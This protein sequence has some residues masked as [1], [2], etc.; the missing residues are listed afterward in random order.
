M[1]VISDVPTSTLA[2]SNV[3]SQVFGSGLIGLREGLEAAIVVSILVAFLVKS[4]R[5]DALK[6]V[7]LGVGAA[8]A[9]TVTV[10]L[11]I[12]F[13]EKTIS[14]LGAEAI[15]GIAS[16]IAVVI[17]TTMVL[18]MKR[19]SASMSGQ[20]R[21][22]MSQALETGGLAVALLAFLAVGREGVETALFMVGYAEAETLWPLTGLIIGV[23]IAAAIAYGMYAGAV[24]INLAKFF[25]YTGIFLVVVAAGILAYGIKALQ[26]VGWIPGLNAKA[27]DMSGAFDWSAWYGEIVQGVFNIDPTPTVLQFSAWLAYIVV[28]LALFLKPIRTAG[29]ASAATSPE[30][31]SEPTAEPESSTTS[32]RSTK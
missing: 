3:T 13:G 20:L 8:I 19:A 5:R 30:T 4:E 22:E 12:Q 18:W 6:W 11:V 27:F 2:A 31:S 28:V 23:L 1:T 26:T 21:G 7:W 14:G 9:M 25:K 24:R 29:A 16:L 10:F 32:E 17:V 15:A